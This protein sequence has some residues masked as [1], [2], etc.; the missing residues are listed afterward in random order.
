MTQSVFFTS[1]THFNHVGAIR[2]R[3]Q[4]TDYLEMN[5]YMIERWNSKVKPGDRVYHLGDFAL[6]KVEEG[7]ALVKRLNGEKYLI[8]GNHEKVAEH[9]SIKHRFVWQKDLFNLKIGDQ[10]IV[11]CHYSMRVWR[12]SHHGAW[13]LYGH[14]H[15]MLKDVVNG[16]KSFDIGVDCW[17]FY[18]LSFEEVSQQM[19]TRVFTPIDHHIGSND[20]QG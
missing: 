11:L 15:G 5:E 12:N 7:S 18:P 20:D 14:S 10:N 13:H 2:F 16:G 1:D 8:I 19:A 17:D 6:G 3:P 4:F 9:P